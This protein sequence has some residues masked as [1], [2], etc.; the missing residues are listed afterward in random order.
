MSLQIYEFAH[1]TESHPTRFLR[2]VGVAEEL[3][4]QSL[5]ERPEAR[6]H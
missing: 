2:R 6:L 3:D 1:G 5:L 4:D